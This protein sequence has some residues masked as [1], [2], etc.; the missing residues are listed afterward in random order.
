[1]SNL[2]AIPDDFMTNIFSSLN[3]QS[4][5]ILLLEEE[6]DQL[7]SDKGSILHISNIDSKYIILGTPSIEDCVNPFDYFS[8]PSEFDFYIST[9]PPPP[10][11][12]PGS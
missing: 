7:Q 8:S 3:Q 2:P 10:P 1:M 5:I 9:L 4:S 12:L 11:P 6:I